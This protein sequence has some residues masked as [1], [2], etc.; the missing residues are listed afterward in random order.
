MRDGPGGGTADASDLKSEG[1]LNHRGGSNPPPGTSAG[2][3]ASC[4]F[5]PFHL[6]G[7]GACFILVVMRRVWD[8]SSLA[9]SIRAWFSRFRS[10]TQF[11]L[12][13][14]CAVFIVQLLFRFA[15]S[16]WFDETFSLSGAGL[17]HGFV[18]QPVTYMFLHGGV[19]HILINM[20]VLWF[21]GREVEFFI[22][23][24]H[25]MRLYF[26]GG[27]AGAALWLAFNWH[28]G[29]VLGASAAILGCVIAFATLFPEREITFLL[30][31]IIPISIKAKYLAWICVAL[32]VVPLLEHEPGNVAHLAHLGGALLGYVYVKQL[33]Y[34][35]PPF[36]MRWVGALEGGLRPRR[37][38]NVSAAEYIREQVDPI[39]DKISR[40]GMQSLTREERA[41]L[42]RARDLMEKKKR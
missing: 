37:S 23:A 40:E 11:L 9:G 36:W 28:E 15:N 32:D 25:Y 8:Q 38:E 1:G 20:L 19:L 41:I 7:P 18:W 42:D 21:I 29:A 24:K 12:V 2:A 39:L 31:F 3:G 10:V 5:L 6:S 14:N 30:W 34:G 33:G 22:G 13:A 27:I 26:L 16:G 17:R 4:G 35:P